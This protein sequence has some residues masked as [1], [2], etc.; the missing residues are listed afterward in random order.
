M[1][2]YIKAPPSDYF[3]YFDCGF[4]LLSLIVS[5]VGLNYNGNV[6]TT[7]GVS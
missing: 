5:I 3:N 6:F 4:I 1:S 2:Q 7:T